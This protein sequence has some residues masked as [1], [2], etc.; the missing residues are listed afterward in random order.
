MEQAT[1]AYVA[2]V[3][4]SGVATDAI[5][6][7]VTVVLARVGQSLAALTLGLAVLVALLHYRPVLTNAISTPASGS[8]A[9][10]LA[11]PL[12]R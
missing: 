8:G 10:A 5:V 3:G 12:A 6:V 1:K 4:V 11:I 9:L 2:A 7:V